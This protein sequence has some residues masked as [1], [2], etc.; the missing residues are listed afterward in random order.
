[1]VRLRSLSSFICG[2]II[3]D[4]ATVADPDPGVLDPDLDS[5]ERDKDPDP[6]LQRK[7]LIPTVLRLF[8][9]DV[10]VG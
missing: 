4:D 10:N 2:K 3:R 5:L 8:V 6:D 7:I 9:N 1:M